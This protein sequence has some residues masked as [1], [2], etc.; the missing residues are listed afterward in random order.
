VIGRLLLA[1][2]LIFE[3]PLGE[4]ILF[5]DANKSPFARKICSESARASQPILRIIIAN[6]SEQ[7][8]F[9]RT[10]LDVSYLLR[11]YNA[12]ADDLYVGLHPNWNFDSFRL[13]NCMKYRGLRVV[14]SNKN[15][16][17]NSSNL[18]INVANVGNVHLRTRRVASSIMEVRHSPQPKFGPVGATRDI[19]CNFG[20]FP[21][22]QVEPQS[23]RQ[24]SYPKGAEPE[25]PPSPIGGLLSRLRGLPL[26]AKIGLVIPVWLAAWGLIFGSAQVDAARLRYA[27]LG[28]GI[29]IALV[30][31]GLA[32]ALK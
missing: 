5:R 12:R 29:F 1:A 27:Q 10:P 26:G 19:I 15:I 31:F 21:S 2:V 3:L 7:A 4:F 14:R 25:L 23:G 32:Y 13:W 16:D 9:G 24:T 22:T 8:Q 20:L 17:P 11:G 30:G 28:L 18:R 6:N